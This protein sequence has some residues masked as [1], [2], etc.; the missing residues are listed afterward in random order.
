MEMSL[1]EIKKAIP[2]V[3]FNVPL[4]NHTTFRIGGNSKFFLETKNKKE[5]ISALKEAGKLGLPFYILGGGSKLL[6]SDDGFNGLIIKLQNKGLRVQDGN[7]IAEAGLSL[8]ELL[9]EA[10]NNNLAGLEW[11]AGIPGTVGGAVRGNAGAWGKSMRN[12]IKKVEAFDTQKGMI[13]ILENREC[14]FGYRSSIFKQNP[15]LVILSCEVALKKGDMAESEKEIIGYLN[16]RKERHPL[17]F[18]SAG[19]I[20]ENPEEYR[21]ADNPEGLPTGIM[22]AECGLAGKRIGNVEISE[23]H[24]NFIINLGKGKAEEVK[25]LIKLA[26]EKVEEKFGTYLKEEIQYLE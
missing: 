11:A 12:I 22:I 26:R 3:R 24:S 16:Y 8:R 10:M 5:I 20:F 19:S 18:P 13:R 21:E 23:K 6:A 17:F 7:I 2:G 25:E 1:S 9:S 4:C 14:N 15:H